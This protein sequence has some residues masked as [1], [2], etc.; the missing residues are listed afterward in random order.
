MVVVVVVVA[1]L[2]HGGVLLTQCD[3]H[4]AD[5][6]IYTQQDWLCAVWCQSALSDGSFCCLGHALAHP[7][8]TEA[9]IM[10]LVEIILFFPAL[11]SVYCNECGTEVLW[12]SATASW[13]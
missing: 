9:G 6:T 7:L 3:F 1:I 5:I 2:A 10:P 13:S 4:Q 12:T 11:L 8:H